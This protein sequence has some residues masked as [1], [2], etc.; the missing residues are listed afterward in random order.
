MNYQHDCLRLVCGDETTAIA[1]PG[2]V[3]SS[4]MPYPMTVLGV[5]ASLTTGP[6]TG[7]LVVDI[8]EEGTSILATPIT[9]EAG[10][11]SSTGSA[12]LP[13]IADETLGDAALIE[14]VILDEASGDA[15]GLKVDIIGHRWI[16]PFG[17]P[18]GF[19]G[20]SGLG[21]GEPPAPEEPPPSPPTVTINQGSGQA[22]PSGASSVVFD[23]V[24]SEAVTGF[25]TGDVTLSGTAGATTGT[26]SGS[27]A[28]YTVT[29]TGMTG[30]GTVIATINA[31]VCTA[32]AT[33]LSNLASTSTDN[34]ITVVA[35]PIQI[36]GSK[37]MAW[38][39]G[40]DP[41]N[42]TPPSNGT[43]V[44]TWED[45]TSNNRDLT[46]RG[47]SGTGA[48]YTANVLN[49][50]GIMRF[51]GTDDGYVRSAFFY[52]N[53]TAEVWVVVRSDESGTGIVISEGTDDGVAG[54]AYR[55][56][57]DDSNNDYVFNLENQG[58]AGIF[59]NAQDRSTNA[60][61]LVIATDRGTATGT[62]MEV[63]DVDA[64]TTGSYSRAVASTEV[65]SVGM[66][67]RIGAD[68]VFFDGDIADILVL[69]SA[70]SSGERTALAAYF[71]AKFAKSW[72]PA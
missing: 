19:S 53:G 46:R 9:L 29:V 35:T 4:H 48:T 1:A 6:T 15:A 42:G 69:S 71:N 22:D 70:A 59:T 32:T 57:D 38:W 44:T 60:W 26:V 10:S 39:D 49:G 21:I 5:R 61:D 11:T 23:V 64:G 30:S 27:G 47:G 24:F 8:E 45:K 36:L 67:R 3:H 17:A 31:G 54:D 66:S 65:L 56:Y 37:L 43:E 13:F 52:N 51:D 25:A 50:N 28:T 63:V 2:A 14:I 7:S 62:S 40:A 41:T 68:T 58:G 12:E 33:G 18:Y 20:P 34:T 72:T 55:I 16:V